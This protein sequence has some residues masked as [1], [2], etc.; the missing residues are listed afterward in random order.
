MSQYPV[1]SV[2]L[3]FSAII[4]AIGFPIVFF[5]EQGLPQYFGAIVGLF[6][7]LLGAMLNASFNRSRDDRLH[8]RDILSVISAIS[9]ETRRN[10]ALLELARSGVVAAEGASAELINSQLEKTNTDIL[11]SNRITLYAA[12]ES[13]KFRIPPELLESYVMNTTEIRSTSAEIK[14]TN[15]DDILTDLNKA[16]YRNDIELVIPI[17]VDFYNEINRLLSHLRAATGETAPE[18]SAS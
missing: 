15:P 10:F 8:N 16:R 6:A 17:A 18:T 4:V 13:T 1:A 3:F 5:N 12:M 2:S 11:D 14:R 7:L 9:N